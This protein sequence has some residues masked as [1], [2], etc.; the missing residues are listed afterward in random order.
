MRIIKIKIPDSVE[1]S[2]Y[3]FSMMIAA[4]LYED[5]KLSSGQA[6]EMVGLT[7]RAFIEILGKYGVSLFSNS[8]DDLH[9]DIANA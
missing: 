5:R 6:A 8:L 9:S 3:D 2:D 4:K 1:L 7:K